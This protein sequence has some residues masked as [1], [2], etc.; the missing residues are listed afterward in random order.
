[1][2]DLLKEK[3]AIPIS[4]SISF[5]HDPSIAHGKTRDMAKGLFLCCRGRVCSG[6][7]AGMGLPVL[8]NERQ[9]FFP[10]LI[11]MNIPEKGI[12]KKNFAF[13]RTLSWYASKRIIPFCFG[14]VVESVAEKYKKLPHLQHLLLRLRDVMFTLFSIHSGMRQ[15]SV[16]E[17]CSVMYEKAHDGLVVSVDG[18]LD[19]KSSR[20]ILMNEVDGRSFNRLRIGE[21][22]LKDHQIPAWK[23]VQSECRLESSSLGI[24]FSIAFAPHTEASNHN[25]FCGREVALDLDWAGFSIE[26]NNPP[27][28]YK[29]HVH[30]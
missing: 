24:G 29:I 14:R 11:S 30:E 22:L 2:N 6:E 4:D 20:I 28:T 23:A 3:T 10:S 16:R 21:T 9:T 17:Y 12:L 5:V 26:A 18:S 15:G 7:S 13:D 1:M 25:L 19:R 27:I 8:K